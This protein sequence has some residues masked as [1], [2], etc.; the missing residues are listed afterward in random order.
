MSVGAGCNIGHAVAVQGGEPVHRV[1][2]YSSGGY[3]LSR[4]TY[5]CVLWCG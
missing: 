4:R 3:G 5:W 1:S 2:S